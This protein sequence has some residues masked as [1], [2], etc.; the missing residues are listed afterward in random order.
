MRRSSA[1]VYHDIELLYAKPWDFAIADVLL[2][3]GGGD[4]D[5]ES[6]GAAAVAGVPHVWLWHGEQDKTVPS[7]WAP[8]IA[9]ALGEQAC[10][11]YLG[12]HDGHVSLLQWR[13]RE[14]LRTVTKE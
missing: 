2:L 3:Q 14:V 5:G 12:A 4:G 13:W 6:D 9:S 1:G 10:T 8:Y 7:A 11:L